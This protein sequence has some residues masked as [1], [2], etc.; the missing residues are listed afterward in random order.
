[1]GVG[2][3]GVAPIGPVVSNAIFAGTGKWLRSLPFD[4]ELLQSGEKF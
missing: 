1:M 3:P 4:F 2:E